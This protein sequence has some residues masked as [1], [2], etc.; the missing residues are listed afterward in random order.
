MASHQGGRGG[1]RGRGRRGGGGARGPAGGGPGG[2]GGGQQGG[3]PGGQMGPGAPMAGFPY[4]SM[5]PGGYPPR[6]YPMG[7]QG[8]Y[9]AAPGGYGGYPGQPMMFGGP[10]GYG[11]PMMARGAP[12][13][14]GPGGVPAGA[15]PPS[16]VPR[17]KK[18]LA[19]VSPDGTDLTA[20]LKAEKAKADAEKVAKK[21]REE[22]EA[23]AA[24]EEA[25]RAAAAEAE[26]TRRRSSAT[27]E[28]VA[29][30]MQEAVKGAGVDAPEESSV[31]R[32]DKRAADPPP[33]PTADGRPSFMVDDETED[34]A[35]ASKVKAEEAAAKAVK[36][37]AA[38]KEAAKAKAAKEAK[39]AEEAKAALTAAASAAPESAAPKTTPKAA[40]SGPKPRFDLSDIKALR[41]EELPELPESLVPFTV[42]DRPDTGAPPELGGRDSWGKSGGRSGTPRSGRSGGGAG[43][44]RRA[45]GRGR[46]D[47][48]RPG[49]P[50]ASYKLLNQA[51]N[52]FK[53]SFGNA[54]ENQD[55]LEAALKQTRSI[56]NKLTRE[57]FGRLSGQLLSIPIT[58]LA[59][60][61]EVI[62]TVFDKALDEPNFGEMYA[63]LCDLLAKNR[64]RWTIVKVTRREDTGKFYFAMCKNPSEEDEWKGP[65]ETEEKAQ[66]E[67]TKASNF[68]RILLNKCQSE[69]EKE[70][71][72]KELEEE[73][74]KEKA[75]FEAGELGERDYKVRAMERE[76]K[77]MKIK[78]RMLGNI[79]FIGELF[80]KNMLTERIMHSCVTKLLNNGDIKTPDE[81]NTEALCKLMTTIGS[82]LDATV[83]PKFRSSIKVYFQLFHKLSEH[84][85][86]PSRIRFMI[87]DL[88]DMRHSGWKARREEDKAMT[89]AEFRR[90]A[91]DDAR[92]QEQ[93]SRAGSRGDRGFGGRHDGPRRGM[94]EVAGRSRLS[95]SGGGGDRGREFRSARSGGGSTARSSGAPRS[96]GGGPR[97]MGSGGPR[98]LGKTGGGPATLGPGKRS[99]PSPTPPASGGAGGR[100][101]GGASGSGRKPA[102]SKSTKEDKFDLDTLKKK[103]D[104]VFDEFMGKAAEDPVKEALECIDELAS[105]GKVGKA[106][107]MRALETA[108]EKGNKEREA[109]KE[110]IPTMADNGHIDEGAVKF[111]LDDLL[112]FYDDMLVDCPQIAVYITLVVAPLV[113]KGRVSFDAVLNAVTDDMRSSGSAAIFTA[114]FL[115]G[116]DAAAR[117]AKVPA[118]AGLIAPGTLPRVAAA[119]GEVLLAQYPVIS[120]AAG[121]A[122]AG[123]AAAQAA[124]VG[125]V[126][127]SVAGDAEF[128]FLVAGAV[129]GQAVAAAGRR[130]PDLEILA[131]ELGKSGAVL[132][133]VCGSGQAGPLKAAAWQTHLKHNPEGLAAGLASALKSAGAASANLE[134]WRAAG[135][136][137]P[138]RSDAESAFAAAFA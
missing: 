6:G 87:K 39:A 111:A 109:M 134:A 42:E 56:L 36:D 12:G 128:S 50:P 95:G 9:M 22:E 89:I 27:R 30:A 77:Q 66:E 5:A 38:A 54:Q 64:D 60:L 41:P 102:S 129:F 14:F 18:I 1:G 63:D 21:K 97:T 80:K 25:A 104:S 130:A 70:G 131:T 99:S 84:R 115:A 26:R 7:A 86:L 92:R 13:S 106:I 93:Q 101:S 28:E 81:E 35:A 79:R 123:D 62:S 114:T 16:L 125:G 47:E 91:A 133:A 117:P 23:K 122:S 118:I 108:M 19:I 31:M 121:V 73:E 53:P 132:G 58:S 96:M 45:Q 8:T 135:G 100:S 68:K 15:A 124:A 37:A 48:I 57:K 71:L 69:F 43:R 11:G 24:A 49:G 138:G 127:G 120:A 85:G 83:E 90:K 46:R 3:Y 78:R 61:S 137:A 88:I 113:S 29:R 33:A 76:E 52:A 4:G 112:E 51:E 55:E 72:Y 20:D 110:W 103:V 119:L 82:K 126:E 105:P 107:M 10:G 17:K 94:P 2:R 136:A 98:M 34:D 74:R 65:Y 67:A 59:M 32:P 44:G 116:V 75:S 40:R